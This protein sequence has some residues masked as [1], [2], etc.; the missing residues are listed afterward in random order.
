ML[1]ELGRE[2]RGPGGRSRFRRGNTGSRRSSRQPRR[3]AGCC[4]NPLRVST[5]ADQS[6]LASVAAM[7]AEPIAEPDRRP[8]ARERILGTA[9]ELFS[10]PGVRAVGIEELIERAGPKATLYRHFPSKDDLV[11]EFLGLREKRWTQ[12]WVEAEARK[13]RRDPRR[14]AAGDLRPL[15]RVVSPQTSKAARSST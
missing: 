5:E 6:V 1:R 8:V 9:Y 2:T 10:R 12:G 4:A 3:R 14:A 13:P 15:R 7:S 11:V